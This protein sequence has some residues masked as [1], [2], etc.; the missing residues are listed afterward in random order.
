MSTSIVEIPDRV[1]A[2]QAWRAWKLQVTPMQKPSSIFRVL[3]E[4]KVELVSLNYPPKDIWPSAHPLEAQCLNF[5]SVDEEWDRLVGANHTIP[6][7]HC[8]CGIY[9]VK[10]LAAAAHYGGIVGTVLLWGKVIEAT[11]GF[12]AQYAYPGTLYLSEENWKHRHSLKSIYNVE[13][14]PFPLLKRHPDWKEQGG[15]LTSSFMTAAN[16]IPV[17]AFFLSS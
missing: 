10:S 12:R 13:C 15:G 4:P 1:S 17:N 3:A 8:T 11:D 6:D 5:R 2:I 9:A 16:W 7:E 14:L